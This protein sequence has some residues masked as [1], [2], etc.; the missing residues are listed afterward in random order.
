[1][2]HDDFDLYESFELE[3][4]SADSEIENASDSGLD[5]DRVAE[6]IVILIDGSRERGSGYLVCADRVITCAHV[7]KN[8]I[9]VHVRFNADSEDEWTGESSIDFVSSKCDTAVLSIQYR[10]NDDLVKLEFGRIGRKNAV[11][12]CS[13]VGYPRF[14]LRDD[15]ERKLPDGT[16]SQY[17]DSFHLNGSVPLLSNQK[18]NS[19]EVSISNPPSPAYNDGSPWE[20]MSGA[21]LFSGNLVIGLISLHYS[22]EGF[23]RLAAVRVDSWYRL[24]DEHEL[25]L[26]IQLLDLPGV[27]TQLADALSP[28]ATPLIESSYLARVRS[29]APS[30]LIDREDDIADLVKF[31]A[32][33]EGYLLVHAPPWAGKTALT[34]WF[35]LNPPAGVRIASFFITLRAASEASSQAFLISMI[36]QLSFIAGVPRKIATENSKRVEQFH[37]LIETAAKRVHEHEEDKLLLIID[38][39]DE[40]SGGRPSIAA[41]LPRNLPFNVLVLVTSRVHPDLPVDVPGQHPLRSCEQRPLISSPHATN[42]EIEAENELLLQLESESGNIDIIG[43]LAACQDSLSCKNLAELTGQPH[44]EIRKKVRASFGRTLR[45]SIKDRNDETY[46]FAHDTLRVMA[47]DL[48]SGDLERYREGIHEWAEDYRTK[49]WPQSTPRYL[50]HPYGKMLLD[51]D[52]FVRYSKIAADTQRHNLML[53]EEML[54]AGA[55]S[56]IITAQDIIG[57]HDFNVTLL[58]MLAIERERVLNRRKVLDTL[59]RKLVKHD[60][61]YIMNDKYSI[62]E[63]I[64]NQVKV[65]TAISSKISNYDR[66]RALAIAVSSKNLALSITNPLRQA[67]PLI[68][69]AVALAH[70]EQW[71][72][73]RL[74]ALEI[75]DVEHR[76]NALRNIAIVMAEAGR[77]E[78][79]NYVAESIDVHTWRIETK[80]H[81]AATLVEKSPK[82]A[83]AIIN[84][85]KD[86][87]SFGESL[88]RERALIKLASILSKAGNTERAERLAQTARDKRTKK[89]ILADAS[90]ELAR[91]G[92]AK[93]A[94]RMLNGVP[95]SWLRDKTTAENSITIA[96]TGNWKVA[97][98]MA[99]TIPD[100]Q[101]RARALGYLGAL[102]LESDPKRGRGVVAE[103]QMLASSLSPSS[104]SHALLDLGSALMESGHF[105]Y[106]EKVMRDIPD[107]QKRARALG[108]LGALLLESDPKRGRGVVAEA[109][110]LAS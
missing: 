4:S 73:S 54:A 26:L 105:S 89:A 108:Y 51:T 58:T 95:R 45:T 40:D 63:N 29:L 14:K 60:G 55:I 88:R 68:D 61:S 87:L 23:A 98:K 5:P 93:L 70:A 47:R 48:L 2:D 104:K 52:D 97:E 3:V 32:S 101:E 106:A 35:V 65:L 24:L 21:A 77:G 100:S 103:A 80:L 28:T 44:Y 90:I 43:Y 10:N 99:R 49:G 34:A 7:I 41:L 79:S 6:I 8:A 53:S 16:P 19:L 109:Q 92:Q 36:D 86:G 82:Q 38:G 94:E 42:L 50:L 69:V 46:V 37:H 15:H 76:G 74:T 1:M 66:G 96:Q 27:E 31:C 72:S 81:L 30:E 78:L 20:G 75:D 12:S 18:Q 56:E 9:S 91:S 33:T 67:G 83:L 107:S 22:T 110:M 102:L 39:L 59:Y 17:R 11:L 84:P 25:E 13:A 62:Q 85:I 71:E 64:P 57:K